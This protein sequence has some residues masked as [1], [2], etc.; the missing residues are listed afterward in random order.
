MQLT[1]KDIERLYLDY[2]NNW[3]TAS[4]WQ[5]HHGLTKHQSNYILKKG[6]SLWKQ[7]SQKSTTR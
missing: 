5:E 2:V 7:S 3:L 4:R 1:N 6:K